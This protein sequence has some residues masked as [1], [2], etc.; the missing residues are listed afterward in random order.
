MT[1]RRRAGYLATGLK[2]S[3]GDGAS[4]EEIE[5]A[6]AAEAECRREE[7]RAGRTTAVDRRYV[8]AEPI[9]L[10]THSASGGRVV[11]RMS[12][13]QAPPTSSRP[14]GRGRRAGAPRGQG[15]AQP[16]AAPGSAGLARGGRGDDRAALPGSPGRGERLSRS[17]A[18]RVRGRSRSRPR[19]HRS[20]PHAGSA[21]RWPCT[22]AA[23]IALHWPT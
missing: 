12:D 20:S 17:R 6:W 1:S 18:R 7:L 3:V 14:G 4:L 10:P 23:P 15:R 22:S 5:A 13:E 9:K 21:R 16:R 2:D 19:G 8:V 11:A